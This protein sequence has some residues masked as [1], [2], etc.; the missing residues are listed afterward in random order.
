ML[1][2]HTLVGKWGWVEYYKRIKIVVFDCEIE[3]FYII[4]DFFDKVKFLIHINLKQILFIDI[5]TS[6]QKFKIIIYHIKEEIISLIP[7][8]DS[9]KSI[10]FLSKILNKAEANYWAIEYEVACLIWTLWKVRYYIESAH[11]TVVYTNHQATTDIVK[12]TSLN[13]FSTDKLN[14]RL[15]RA[16]QYAS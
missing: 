12:A 10:I 1:L 5:N 7:P 15:I 2:K 13:S 8:K 9:I 3:N 6:K 16:S 11:R 4:K 14:L